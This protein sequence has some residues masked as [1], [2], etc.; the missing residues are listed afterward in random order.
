MK[1]ISFIMV[2]L[3]F[4]GVFYAQKNN[5]PKEEYKNQ[6]VISSA[7]ASF[8]FSEGAI[9]WS[10]GDT[11]LHL[12][13][14]D[15]DDINLENLDFN[16]VAYPNPTNNKLNITHNSKTNENLTITIY[17]FN[18]RTL[19]R[20]Q[21]MQQKNVINLQGLPAELYEIKITNSKNQMVKSFKII[22]Y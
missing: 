5:T 22:K 2:F 12:K 6:S 4:N 20:K 8:E 14:G 10:L 11:V 19:M 9:S 7:S 17:D 15:N 18:G 3:L 16:V 21:L 13:I 1:T